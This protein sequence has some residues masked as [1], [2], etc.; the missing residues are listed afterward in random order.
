MESAAP[1]HESTMPTRRGAWGWVDDRL[2]LS[3]LRYPV[4]EHGNTLAYTLG[5]ITLV[6]FVL[7]VVTG[8]YLAQYYDPGSVDQAHASVFYIT[9]EAFLGSLTRSLHYWLAAAFVVTLLLHMVRTFATGAFKAPRELTWVSGVLLFGLGAGALFSGTVLKADQESVEALAHNN[10]IADFFGVFGFWFSGD[11]TDAVGPIQRQY[12]AHVSIVPL[13]I[14]VLIAVHMLLIKRHRL[15]PLPWG[16]ADEVAARERDEHSVPFTSHL[17]HIGLWGLV[18]L[19][20]ALILSGLFPAGLGPEGAQGIEITKPPWYFLWL[21]QPEN[22]FGLNALWIFSALLFV[23]LLLIPVV[24][25]SPER[26][27]RR[28]KLWIGLGG[29]VLIG[30]VALTIAGA[31]AEVASHVGM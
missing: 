2:G 11:F 18:V 16:S 9:N 31:T 17:R 4:P 7:L 22:W 14:A 15:S 23:G 12:V 10:E 25:R 8:I 26:D 24:D 1:P 27:P 30:W 13:L 21:Y 6:T 5:G 29:L 28:R 3:A 20:V 19:G